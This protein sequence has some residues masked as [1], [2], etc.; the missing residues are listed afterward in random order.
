M[1][2]GTL[3]AIKLPDYPDAK[4][5]NEFQRGLMFQDFVIEQLSKRFGLVF[6]MFSSRIYQWEAGEGVQP[7]E[8]KMDDGWQKYNRL[9]IEVA[10]KSKKNVPIWTPSGIMREDKTL[11]YVHGNRKCFWIFFKKHLRM[12]YEKERPEIAEKFGTIKT[13]YIPVER[14]NKIGERV[15]FETTQ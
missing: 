15:E 11:F 8:I 1:T 12:I 3:G 4:H 2:I 5:D 7:F 9:S 6:Q 13:F 10:E 14:A